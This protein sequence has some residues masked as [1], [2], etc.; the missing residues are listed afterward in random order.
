MR[1]V[2]GIRSGLSILFFCIGIGIRGVCAQEPEEAIFK[3]A[4]NEWM[5]GNIQVLSLDTAV[6]ISLPD[7]AGKLGYDYTSDVGK[8]T[9]AACLPQPGNCFAFRGDTLSFR[10]RDTVCTGEAIWSGG[11]LFASRRLLQ[12]LTDINTDVNYRGLAVILHADLAFPV[13]LRQ[14]QENARQLLRAA[15]S[16]KITVDSLSSPTFCLSSLGYSAAFYQPLTPGVNSY[17]LGGNLTGIILGGAFHAN[18][19]YSSLASP[20]NQHYSTFLWDHQNVGY[21]WIR[22]AS[23]F[24]RYS[25]FIMNT[26]GYANGVYLSNELWGQ[27]ETRYYRLNA[28]ALPGQ[29]VEIYNNGRFIDYIRADSNGS[30]SCDIPMTAGDNLVTSTTYDE[31]AHPFSVEKAVRLFPDMQ[32]AGKFSY[33]ASAGWVDDGNKFFTTQ[34]FYGVTHFLTLRAGNETLLDDRI[35]TLF[36][37]GGSYVPGKDFRINAEYIPSVRWNTSLNM[38]YKN[39]IHSTLFYERYQKNQTKVNYAPNSHLAFD[40]S[41]ELPV[42]GLRSLLNVGVQYYEYPYM[43]SSNLNFRQNFYFRQLTAGWFLSSVSERFFTAERWTYGVRAGYYLRKGWNT[44][45]TYEYSTFP[46]QSRLRNRTNYQRGKSLSFYADID[47]EFCYR[48]YFLS[49]GVTWNLSSIRLRSSVNV[50]KRSASVGTELAGSVLLYRKGRYLFTNNSG[51]TSLCV[52]VFLD[53]NGDGNYDK[54]EQIMPDADVFVHATSETV[55]NR[56]GIFFLNLPGETPFRMVIPGQQFKD[57]DWQVKPYEKMLILS[58]FQE[59]V[60]FIPVHVVSEISGQITGEAT[61]L[62]EI[63]V[64]L[65]HL[66]TGR[67]QTIMSDLWGFFTSSGITCGRYSAQISPDYLRSRQLATVGQAVHEFEI[68]MGKDGHQIN[69]LNFSLVK[70]NP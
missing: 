59:E 68:P 64:E 69:G 24:R 32:P 55:R 5:L 39:K 34:W 44:E 67:K 50:S 62:S 35:R 48:N 9:F 29:E 19:N 38:G 36:T 46:Y 14:N 33:K 58:E 65:T 4:A 21:R 66:S 20:G 8:G 11:Q 23:V 45:L 22:Q 12:Y 49:V 25:G 40:F 26:S 42:G 51:A 28:V 54:G 61:S 43:Q 57:I 47:Y 37:F 31:F 1:A 6:W 30:Y 52:V 27:V 10:G 16:R 53:E 17:N 18:Y 3:F 63:P 56:R 7:F 70:E 15:A 13:I 2:I 41:A 60:I